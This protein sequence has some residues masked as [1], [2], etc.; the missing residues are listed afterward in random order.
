MLMPTMYGLKGCNQPFS[1]RLVQDPN[2]IGLSSS[3]YTSHV[4]HRE[5]SDALRHCRRIC[6]PSHRVLGPS[7]P[8]GAQL[9]FRIP[10]RDPGICEGGSLM[11]GSSDPKLHQE[12]QHQRPQDRAGDDGNK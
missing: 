1:G 7:A 6:L 3:A 2:G 10:V 8:T 12:A 11:P 9:R 5:E 4:V